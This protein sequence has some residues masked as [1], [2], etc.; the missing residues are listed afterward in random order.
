MFISNQF[1][2]TVLIDTQDHY[3]SEKAAYK[4]LS[5][6]QEQ[7]ILWL[8]CHPRH[9]R[10]SSSL[11]V[12]LYMTLL[13]S[14]PA[15]MTL[16][17]IVR[18]TFKI[19]WFSFTIGLVGQNQVSAEADCILH[20]DFAPM[21]WP[22]MTWHDTGDFVFMWWLLLRDRLLYHS[23]SQAGTKK[24]EQMAD[25]RRNTCPTMPP[26]IAHTG[27]SSVP[28]ALSNLWNIFSGTRFTATFC[29]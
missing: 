8:P 17:C 27:G 7:R 6:T 26:M 12:L 29:T 14:A 9:Q 22:T 10:R 23:M 19:A 15:A 21:T 5:F 4:I 11:R 3:R 28:P 1:H 16:T 2:L 24:N 18:N 13:L 25:R 20:G